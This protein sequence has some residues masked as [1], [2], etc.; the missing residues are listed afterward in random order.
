MM[1]H[2]RHLA[3]NISQQSFC[4]SDR[5]IKTSSGSA[6]LPIVCKNWFLEA[7][8]TQRDPFCTQTGWAW[9]TRIYREAQGEGKREEWIPSLP[10][11]HP[12]LCLF[13]VGISLQT[14]QVLPD[15]LSL[16]LPGDCH[17]SSLMKPPFTLYGPF[18]SQHML[19]GKKK[20]L[21]VAP[22]QDLF[23]ALQTSLLYTIE[24]QRFHWHIA[25]S[26]GCHEIANKWI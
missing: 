5:N 11:V 8:C 10:S 19:T 18:H 16:P 12:C 1:E 23:F 22:L 7:R 13:C 14:L 21:L 2:G 17:I 15:L 20:L 4:L 3:K 9:Q 6:H 26:L 25:C 24:R